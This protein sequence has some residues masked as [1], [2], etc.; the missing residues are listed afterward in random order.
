MNT[1]VK[2][3][4]AISTYVNDEIYIGRSLLFLSWF[5]ICS[6]DYK[7]TLS[8]QLKHVAMRIE[9]RMLLV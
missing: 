6:F 9:E 1:A 8:R 7:L 3:S 4:S 2:K 5:I